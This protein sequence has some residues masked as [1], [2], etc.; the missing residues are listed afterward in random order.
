MTLEDPPHESPRPP[1]LE[2]SHLLTGP[3]GCPG[4]EF[5]DLL[6]T[7]RRRARHRVTI[8]RELRHSDQ[9]NKS[10]HAGT[11][12][13]PARG[14]RMFL[15]GTSCVKAPPSVQHGGGV[16]CRTRW[17]PSL[18]V[19]HMRSDCTCSVFST[20]LG[21]ILPSGCRV[22]AGG[23]APR[24]PRPSTLEASHL[25]TGPTGCPGFEF[26]GLLGTIRRRA[27]HRVTICRGFRYSDQIDESEHVET[28]RL[29]SDAR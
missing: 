15:G 23:S 29:F 2:A 21:V 22:D 18:S 12:R 27:R 24:K 14:Q 13:P 4:F 9:I 19:P 20:K 28:D 16:N 1:T 8:C 6:G 7:I 26:S 3:T 25:L 10:E 17:R 5:S 11:D